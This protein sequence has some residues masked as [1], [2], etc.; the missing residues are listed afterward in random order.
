[1]VFNGVCLEVHTH[2]NRRK[3]VG[4]VEWQKGKEVGVFS[5]VETERLDRWTPGQSSSHFNDASAKQES[6]IIYLHIDETR[7][8]LITKWLEMLGQKE[9]K[10]NTIKCKKVQLHLSIR[11]L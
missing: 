5:C 3:C 7:V 1:M 10:K 2:L 6:L 9:E 11:D 4:G 8:P